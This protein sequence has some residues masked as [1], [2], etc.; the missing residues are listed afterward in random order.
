VE[1]NEFT[2]ESE[3]VLTEDIKHW[4]EPSARKRPDWLE[5][6]LTVDSDL[7]QIL[8][9]IYT[10]LDSGSR[11]LPAVGV[12][13]AFDRGSELVG[14]DP[15]ITFDEKLDALHSGGGIGKTERDALDVMTDAGSA[16]AHR[17]WR[18]NPQELNTMLHLLEAFVHRNFVISDD[19]S[20][21]KNAVPAKQKRRP[22]KSPSA[23]DEE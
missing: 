22:K 14:I 2:G 15:A 17:G 12:R 5:S 3:Y 13:T 4:P 1:V 10:A 7:Y 16:S 6:L 19:V 21:L 20:K 8:A 11:T 9:E 18:P 23:P